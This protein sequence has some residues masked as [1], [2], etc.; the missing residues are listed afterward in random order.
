METM[1]RPAGV[2]ATTSLVAASAVHALWAAGSNWP[3]DDRDALADLV[4]GTRPFPSTGL[5]AAVA[6]G[7][8][9]GAVVVAC[10]AGLLR[11][12]GRNGRLARYGTW[13][14]AVA[15]LVRGGGGL[16]MSALDLGDLAARYRRWDLILYSPFCI[17]V[18]LACAVV[19]FKRGAR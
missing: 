13:L 19:A 4:S 18:G 2:V 7:L 12:A 1:A 15:F 14:I 17:A 6:G 5:T 3:A 9:A 11:P 10:R 16:V 8:A